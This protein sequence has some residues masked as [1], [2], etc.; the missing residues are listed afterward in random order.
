LYTF[1]NGSTPMDDLIFAK[2]T[3]HIK[4]DASGVTS[5]T[6]TVRVVDLSDASAAY[7]GKVEVAFNVLVG[8]IFRGVDLGGRATAFLA[9]SGFTGTFNEHHNRWVRDDGAIQFRH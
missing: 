7:L 9:N 6:S 1:T 4:G 2:N 5:G 3:L 8:H